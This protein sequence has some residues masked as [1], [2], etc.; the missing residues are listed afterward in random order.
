MDDIQTDFWDPRLVGLDRLGFGAFH[1]D[2]LRRGYGVIC[3]LTD[4]RGRTVGSVKLTR[5]NGRFEGTITI[6][7]YPSVSLDI[8]KTFR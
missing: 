6:P 2:T 3:N 1:H 5:R 8:D 7:G 4:D